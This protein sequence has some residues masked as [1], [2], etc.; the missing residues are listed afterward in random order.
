SFVVPPDPTAELLYKNMTPEWAVPFVLFIA[1]APGFGEE[2]FFRG[3]VQRRLLRR[4]SPAWAVLVTSGVFAVMHLMRHTVVFAFAVGLWLGVVAWRTN[5]IWPGAVC[6]AFINGGWNVL[7]IGEKLGYWPEEPPAVIS[8][9]A[10]V[11]IL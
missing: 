7:N 4:W 1:L 11:V 5:S 2:L 8:V 10:T 9:G 6:H 3:Y